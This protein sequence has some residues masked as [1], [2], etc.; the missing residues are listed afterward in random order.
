LNQA[1]VSL[2]NRCFYTPVKSRI[3]GGRKMFEEEWWEE[4]EWIEEEEEWSDLEEEEW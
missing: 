3:L 2:T 1:S 4:E